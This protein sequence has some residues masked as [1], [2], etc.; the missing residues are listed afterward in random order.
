MAKRSRQIQK[1]EPNRITSGSSG[2]LKDSSPMPKAPTQTSGRQAVRCIFNGIEVSPTTEQSG[3][4]LSF[5]ALPEAFFAILVM[6]IIVILVGG[7]D[8]F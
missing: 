6:G 8:N 3:I 2:A 5:L 1:A 4:R 7:Y